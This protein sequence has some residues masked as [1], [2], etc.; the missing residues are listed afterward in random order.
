LK[1]DKTHAHKTIKKYQIFKERFLDEDEEINKQA[2]MDMLEGFR[3]DAALQSPE[4]LARF[5]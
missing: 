2:T 5:N 1:K 3:K 4:C